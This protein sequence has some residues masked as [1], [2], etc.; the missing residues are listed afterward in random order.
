MAE[1]RNHRVA[2]IL[3]IISGAFALMGFLMLLA[4]IVITS[5]ALRFPG[6][7]AIPGFV[8]VI[9]TIIAVPTLA[10]GV[11]AL[12]GGI[13]ALQKKSWGLVLAGSIASLLIFFVLGII[14]IVFTVQSKD[15]FE[16]ER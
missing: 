1:S 9:L 3:N 2:G 8:P 15:E 11:L 12:A 6:M 14:A 13:F 16:E 4:G 7:D 10:I 5:N